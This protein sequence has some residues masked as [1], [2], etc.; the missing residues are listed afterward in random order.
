MQVNGHRSFRD[1][2]H[3]SRLASVKSENDPQADDLALTL[4]KSEEPT[5]Q[6][7]VRW[8]VVRDRDFGQDVC[9]SPHGLALFRSRAEPPS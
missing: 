2:E 7:W 3:F 4:R 5:Y 6:S 8:W 1:P 9:R